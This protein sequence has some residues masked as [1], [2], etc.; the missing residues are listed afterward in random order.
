MVYYNNN[1]IRIKTIDYFHA[2]RSRLGGVIIGF[3]F[4]KG[5]IEDSKGALLS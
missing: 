2:E 4:S 5:L 3:S 1:I